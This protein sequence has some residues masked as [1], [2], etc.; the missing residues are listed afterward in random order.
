MENKNIPTIYIENIRCKLSGVSVQVANLLSKELAI[1]VP[2]YWFSPKFKAGQWDGTQKF[3][4]RP[5]NTFPTGLLPKVMEFL[6]TNC[7]IEPELIDR[8]LDVEKYA[9]QEI[10]ENY[11]I[12]EEKIARDYQVDT[13]NLLITKKI[14]SVPF[15]RGVVNIAT[16]GG[17]TSIAIAVIKELYPKLIDNNTTFLFVT[18]S[19]EIARQTKIAIEK[20]LGIEVG[21]IGDGKWDI[22]PV[23][24][25]IVT[26][27]YKRLKTPEFKEL[28]SHTIGFVADECLSANAKILLPNNKVMSIKE[29]CERDD[30][31]EVVSYNTETNVF[32]TKKILRKIVTPGTEQF[33]KIWYRDPI[34]GEEKGLT[35]TKNHKIWTQNRGYVRV[36]ELTTDDVIKVN[37]SN[38]EPWNMEN[39]EYVC[40][41]CGKHIKSKAGYG[42]HMNTHSAHY[43]EGIKKGA[44]TRK[45]KYKSGEMKISENQRKRSSEWMKSYNSRPE[46][47]QHSKERCQTILQAEEIQTLRK[48]NWRKRFQEDE[49]FRNGII[50]RFKNAPLYVQGKMTVLENWVVSLGIPQI[51]YTGDG[52]KWFKFSEE[53]TSKYGKKYKN[54]D[55]IIENGED[56]KVIEVGD[57]EYWHTPEEINDVIKEY[58]KLGYECLYLTSVDILENPEQSI[59]KIQKFVF[60]HN[61]KITKISKS[62]GLIPKYKYNLEVE[63]NHN[64]FADN[65]LVSNCHH[66]SSTSWYE[67][68]NNMP[69]ALIRIGLTG[70]VDKKNPVNEMRL[71]SC[72][73]EI[74]NRISN[75]YLIEQGFSAKPI[76]ILFTV[77][78]PELEK[79]PYADAYNLGIV[80]SEERLDYITQICEK[81]TESGNTVLILVEH[82][83]HGTIIK[84]ELEKINKRVF[85]TNGTLTSDTRQ[86]LLDNLKSGK[87]DV[88]ISTSILDEGVDVS[89]IN[90]VIYARGMKSSRK[91]L[92]GIGRGLRKKV[93]GSKLRF[94]DFIDDMSTQLLTHSMNRYQV[95]KQENFVIKS[96]KIE[97]YKQMS[98]EEIE[99]E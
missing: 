8:R 44:E 90:A 83:E 77:T 52:S 84:E 10:P 12:S 79:E 34:T 48:E 95:L 87:I 31:T 4:T 36:D 76:C 92:Q 1:K 24:I 80:E 16:N 21:M 64:Y 15:T 54:P 42:G 23:T 70:T 78:T 94:Y 85:F 27:L 20:D 43:E 86:E 58:E 22:K 35:A 89:N 71:Y 45:K 33:W 63:D 57:V 9:L 75:E 68:F 98:W 29:V 72:T 7:D 14:G 37:T 30:V 17:K 53:Y 47:K 88:L 59:G 51:H 56:K 38:P 5:A 50:T 39:G 28:V 62:I 91:L 60:N 13:V 65:I 61:V 2:N 67:V 49:E 40:P 97:D 46:V 25:S 32:E 93:D 19:K 3:F 96:L 26:T 18:H 69:N 66:S 11:Q 41:V 81:E 55:F 82:L 73:G 99:S 74:I 6:K